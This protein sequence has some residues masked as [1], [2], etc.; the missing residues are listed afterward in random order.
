MDVGKVQAFKLNS[1]FH[2][3]LSNSGELQLVV[4][5]TWLSLEVCKESDGQHVRAP[6]EQVWV[7]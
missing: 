4:M 3:M 5:L 7:L 1:P 6:D 2:L